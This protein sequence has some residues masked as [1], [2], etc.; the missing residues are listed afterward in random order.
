[1]TGDS[2][3]P[4]VSR[5]KSGDVEAFD[6]AYERYRARL[7]TFLVRLTKDRSLAVDLL[8]ETWIRL[9]S[10]AADLDDGTELGPWLFTVARNLFI[11]YRRW[12]FLD[13]ERLRELHL[14]PR[15][16]VDSPFELTAA[17]ELE[18]RTEAALAALPLKY[19]EALL[20][21]VVEK[22]EP[23]Q[24]ARVLGIEPATFRQRLARAR[25]MIAERIHES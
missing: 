14:W 23:T 19:R 17:T 24:A 9:A 21:T 11:S 18:K 20:L 13:A 2:D 10:K 6:E 15:G 16:R 22:L 8:Q 7:F 3:T 5:L 25:G 12:A 1:M 4:L